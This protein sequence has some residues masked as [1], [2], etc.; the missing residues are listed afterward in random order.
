MSVNNPRFPH[1]CKITRGVPSDDP[2]EDEQEPVVIYE[3]P[4]RGYEKNTTSI[5]GEIITTNR[6]LSLPKS[7]DEWQRDVVPQ[8]GDIVEVDYGPYTEHGKVID[9]MVA[10]FHGTHVIWKYVKG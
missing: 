5:S 6:G 9:K 1:T 8:E 10:N 4:C 3:G 7:K 2:M